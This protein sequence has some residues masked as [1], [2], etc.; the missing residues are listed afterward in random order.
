M[1][2]FLYSLVKGIR[3]CGENVSVWSSK[4]MQIFSESKSFF[5]TFLKPELTERKCY[6]CKYATLYMHCLV[7]HVPDFIFL[8]L[9]LLENSVGNLQKK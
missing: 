2:V 9:D 1:W 8:I 4:D 7:Y 6:S 3:D 5:E